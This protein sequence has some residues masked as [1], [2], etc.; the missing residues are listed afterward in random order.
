MADET[1]KLIKKINKAA[2]KIRKADKKKD[3]K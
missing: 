2:K 1:D 3:N